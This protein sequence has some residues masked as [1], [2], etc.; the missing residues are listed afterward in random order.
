MT[1]TPSSDA[2][3]SDSGDGRARDARTEASDAL[4]GSAVR[5]LEPSPPADT[6]DPQ[7]LADDPPNRAAPG[8]SGPPVSA[9]VGSG[10]RPWNEV[11]EDQPD[12]EPFALDRWLGPWRRLPAS[13]PER[14][15]ETRMA[16][17]RVALYVLSD[18]RMD[19]IGKMALRHTYR[20]FGTPFF[21]PDDRQIR[22]EGLD[23]VDQRGSTAS[24]WPITTLAD[25]ADRIGV[26]IDRSKP[27]TFDVPDPGD[28]DAPLPID[29]EAAAFLADWYG[30]GWSVLEQVRSDTD[31]DLDPTRPQLW[32]EHFDPAL[33]AGDEAAGR[34]SGFGASPGDHHDGADPEPYLYL[35]LWS[36]DDVDDDDFWN[37]PFGAKLPYAE[38][39]AAD[40]QRATAIDFFSRGRSLLQG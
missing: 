33:E 28:P 16:L 24:A 13:V 23:L 34:R 22:V 2:T 39:A 15:H 18:A 26:E 8:E 3:A 4:S 9:V 10:R 29:A 38:L 36:R 30:F 5:L 25:A 35:S 17:H 14:Y 21:G 20:G 37:A 31:P 27:D 11:V 6:D 32:P 7:Y 1:D 40:D 19:A 12:L